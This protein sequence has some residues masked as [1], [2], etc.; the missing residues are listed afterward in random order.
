MQASQPDPFGT[1]ELRS[2][3]LD[4]WTAS[5]ARFREDAN[6][7]EDYALGGYRDRVITELAQNAADAAARGGVPGR[8]RLTLAAGT[9]VAANTGAPLDAAGVAALSTLRASSKRGPGASGGAVG[10]FGVGFAAAVA[11]SDEPQIASRTG[12]V[13]WSRRAAADLVAARPALAAEVAARSGHVPVLR[14]PFAAPG[15]PP[16]GFTTAVT[17]PL[18]DAAAV[19]LVERLL[20]DTG[21]AL[22]LALPALA[23]VEIEAGGT[24][25]ELTAAH[26]G[27]GV[28]ITAGGT[29]ARWRTVT[30][31]G[32][33]GA[34]LLADRPAEERARPSWSVRWAVPVTPGADGD[35]PAGRLP[36]GVSA[37]VHAPTPTDEPLG[38]PALLLASFPLSPDRRHVAPGPLT[39]FLTARAAGAYARLL[40]ALAPGPAL[41]GLVP[42]RP[43]SASSM[44]GSAARSWTG[45]PRPPSCPPPG[46][47]ACGSGRGTRSSWTRPSPAWPAPWPRCCP[48][49]SPGL[50]GTRPWPRSASGGSGWPSWPTCSPRWTATRP[51]GAACT[52]RWPPRSPPSWPSSA[53]CPCRWLTG[54][55]SAARAG[56]CCPVPG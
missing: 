36:D 13:A 45:C 50:P 22:L 25:R 32:T 29:A 51:G 9:L 8:L 14:L 39:D 44:P 3:V 26:D 34:A 21:P 35:T 37:V 56:C 6:A 19:A 27:D 41:L 17:L 11:V 15:E 55:W 24:A 12:A 31:G 53:R 4:A 43:G 30:D 49:W 42:A 40:P 18:R 23:A 7:E 1:A 16:A 54:G 5:P 52:A 38:L 48:A 33:A 10:R 20:A 2:A 46:S 28:T 47:P